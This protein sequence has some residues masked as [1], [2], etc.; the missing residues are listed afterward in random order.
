MSDPHPPERYAVVP[1]TME[2]PTCGRRGRLELH[3]EQIV[4][5]GGHQPDCEVLASSQPVPR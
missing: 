2:C 4:W 1:R 3:R 5:R